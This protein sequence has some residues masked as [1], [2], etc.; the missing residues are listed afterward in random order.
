MDPDLIMEMANEAFYR[1]Q[2]S[3]FVCIGPTMILGDIQGMHVI[4]RRGA[5]VQW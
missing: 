3:V 2:Y 1:Q 4:Q 5:V